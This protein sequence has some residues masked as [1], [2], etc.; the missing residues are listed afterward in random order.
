MHMIWLYNEQ[1][2]RDE[3]LKISVEDHGF[4]YGVGLFETFRVYDS[5]PFL[6]EEHI[7]RLQNGLK[8]IGIEKKFDYLEMINL[9]NILLEANNFKNAYVRITVTGGIAPIGLPTEKYNKPSIIWQI[10]PFQSLEKGIPLCKNAILL[11]TKR[12]LPETSI[13]LKSLNFLNNVIAKQ[14]TNHLENTEG[15]FLTNEGYIA[16]GIVSNIFFVKHN[17]LYTPSLEL[18]IL[19]GITREHII[20]LCKKNNIPYEEGFYRYK[21]FINAN[22]IFISNSIQEIVPIIRFENKDFKLDNKGTTKYLIGEYKKTIID[23]I[24]EYRRGDMFEA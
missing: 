11:K 22:E 2:I 7:K 6:F 14:E 19:N 18:G 3:E 4:L 1:L 8:L 21:D 15:V 5:V 24:M 17:K 10:K 20:Y 9:L 12:N 13:R 23:K 16:E